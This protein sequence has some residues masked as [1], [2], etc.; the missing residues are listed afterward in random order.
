MVYQYQFLDSYIMVMKNAIAVEKWWRIHRNSS[1]ISYESCIKN[2]KNHPIQTKRSFCRQICLNL[3]PMTYLSEKIVVV[4]S[5]SHVRCFVTPAA[6]LA[7]LSFTISQT[8]QG[9]MSTEL[10]MPSNHLILCL[11]LSFYLQSFPASESFL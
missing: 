8:L 1:P 6:C 9:L 7:S 10:V 11:P 3:P 5:L 4:H 2:F